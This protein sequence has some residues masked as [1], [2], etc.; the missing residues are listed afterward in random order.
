MDASRE[1]KLE[2]LERILQSRSLRG[3]EGLRAFLRFI[4]TES[5]ENHEDQLKEYTI[6]TQVFGRKDD[7]DP[8]IE[9][10]VRVQAGRLRLK[11]QEFYANEGKEDR[12][13]IELPKGSYI[14]S[15]SYRQ[16]GENSASELET[17]PAPSSIP[18]PHR[19]LPFQTRMWSLLSALFLV[20]SV[21]LG[22]AAYH[23][24]S[25][26]LKSKDLPQSV[27]AA[28]V[29]EVKAALLLWDDFLNSSQ[30]ILV[31]YSNTVFQGTP[32]GGMKLLK[33][34]DSPGT[35]DSSSMTRAKPAHRDESL[36]IDHY[37]GVGEVASVYA[38]GNLF[39]RAGRSFALKRSLVM[40]WDDFKTD[41][42]VIL[43]STA[44]NLIAREIPQQQDFVFRL[45]KFPDGS[46][47]WG[48]INIHPKPGEQER[49]F[50]T[51]QGSYTTLVS[52][53]YALI[54]M[55]RGLDEEHRLV[56]LAGIS[57]FGTQA[58]AEYVTKSEHVSDLIRRLDI[59]G[60]KT[61]PALPRHYQVLIRARIKGGVP[62]EISYVT[63]HVLQ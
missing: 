17:V 18:A 29:P 25:E 2:Q 28:E 13:L 58:A 61:S 5:I 56:N 46:G 15:F 37:T 1:E 26:L 3:S 54:S 51:P 40:T 57:T 10:A 20:S 31:A 44:E 42:V 24:R 49:Y 39:L 22:W 60:S 14:P 41:N 4:V 62:V 7:Y 55:L 16:N 19:A 21:I 53:D 38:L 6:A 9:S 23:Y 12:V 52:E 36:I 59:S 32:E 30:P 8:R 43:G 27:A 48:I 11:L 34:L 50:T 47:A 45:V 33:T 63:H 35:I